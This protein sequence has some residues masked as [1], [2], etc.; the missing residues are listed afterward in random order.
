MRPVMQADLEVR[1]NEARIGQSLDQFT[2]VE[3]RNV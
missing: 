2:V 1:V 3:R